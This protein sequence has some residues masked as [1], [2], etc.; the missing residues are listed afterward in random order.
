MMNGFYKTPVGVIHALSK[1]I[2]GKDSGDGVKIYDPTS[3]SEGL[4]WMSR[5]FQSAAKSPKV[6]LVLANPPFGS[7]WEAEKA[8]QGGGI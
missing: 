1:L 5:S 3:G 8:T 4:S 2:L 7:R 6:K